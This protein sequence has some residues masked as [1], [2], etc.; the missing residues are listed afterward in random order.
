MKSL[1]ALVVAFASLILAAQ[2]EEPIHHEIRVQVR[3]LPVYAFD[4]AG[5]PVTDLQPGELSLFVNGKKINSLALL[6]KKIDSV[7]VAQ[8]DNRS[9]EPLAIA[10]G[11][12]TFLIIDGNGI[13]LKQLQ[14]LK[15]ILIAIV[16]QAGQ[17]DRFILY[18]IFPTGNIRLIVGPE[19]SSPNLINRIEALTRNTISL[20]GPTRDPTVLDIAGNSG[21]SYLERF[22]ESGFADESSG[23]HLVKAIGFIKHALK[24][25]TEPKVIYLISRGFPFD[26]SGAANVRRIAAG[27]QESG[28]TVFTIDTT[29]FAMP[30]QTHTLQSI[31]RESGGRFFGYTQ[32][33]QTATV[34]RESE[35]AYYEVFFDPGLI[36][37]AGEYR[38]DLRCT[39]STVRLVTPAALATFRKY[40]RLTRYEKELLAVDI[41]QNGLWSKTM[42]NPIRPEFSCKSKRSPETN[43]TTIDVV[44]PAAGIG[45]VADMFLIRLRRDDQVVRIEKL[46]RNLQALESILFRSRPDERLAF[47]ILTR[48][49]KICLAAM[50]D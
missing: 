23:N 45:Q 8:A 3:S 11:R 47:V 49:G 42:F 12:M 16:A 14:R 25:F 2:L 32:V 29:D 17:D 10:S 28:A 19:P 15:K 21:E 1:I 30:S 9:D 6:K 31:A 43:V 24:L 39:R 27:F 44:I 48:D 18:T 34:I 38:V 37:S 13:T 46:E 41:L 7:G 33:E 22:S 20:S 50:I 4:Q 40:P 5:A 35:K 26:V 36:P